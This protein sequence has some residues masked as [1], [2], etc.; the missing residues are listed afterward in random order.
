MRI[1]DLALSVSGGMSPRRGQRLSHGSMPGRGRRSKPR[2][3]GGLPTDVSDLH[4][5]PYPPLVSAM[6]FGSGGSHAEKFPCRSNNLDS[7]PRKE[8]A[9][10]MQ[11]C[12]RMRTRKGFTL[13]E[14]AVVIVIIGV[15]A[16]FGVPKFLNPS[17]SPR[18]GSFNYLSA[19]QAAQ[20]RYLAQNGVYAVDHEPR[21]HPSLPPVFNCRHHYADG[22]QRVRRTGRSHSIATRI[23][24][25]HYTVVW[26]Q[27]G[28]DTTTRPS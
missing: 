8:R 2:I 20:E 6:R 28:F 25:M 10:T 21:H 26:N 3:L 18:H 16:A 27:D 9:T 13:V 11:N 5:A 7:R 17:R 22:Q 4:R 15:L 24:A 1:C 23:R 14:L 12:H 19:I